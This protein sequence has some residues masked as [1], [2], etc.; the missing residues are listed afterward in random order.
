[1]NRLLTS[2][3]TVF[4]LFVSMGVRCQTVSADDSIFDIKN[5]YNPDIPLIIINTVNQEE[6]VYDEIQAPGELWGAGITNATKVP[7]SMK[8]MLCDS[9]MY[10]SGEYVSKTSG[11]TVK[12]RGNTSSYYKKKPYKIKLQRKDDLLCRG[13]SAKYGDKDWLLIYSGAMCTRTIVGFWVNELFGM[14]WTPQC[15]YVNVVMNGKYRGFYLLTEAVERNGSCRLNVNKQSGY[16]MEYDAYW[17]NE[18]LYVESGYSDY[19]NYTFKYP[20]SEDVTPEQIQYITDATRRMEASFSDGTYPDHIDVESFAAWLLAHD[21]LGT[22]DS[23]GS[24]MFLTKFNEQPENKFTMGNLWDFDMI[25]RMDGAWAKVHED[26]NAFFY[27]ALF[28]SENKTF[29]EA[30]IRKWRE[31]SDT[32]VDR[33]NERL[34]N[35]RS[36]SLASSVEHYHVLDSIVSLW[37]GDKFDTEIGLHKEWFAKRKTWMDNAV[38]NMAL[39]I[40]TPVVKDDK[41]KVFYNLQGQRVGDSYRGVVICNGRKYIKR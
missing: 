41:R 21:L 23:G 24:N 4:M 31:V 29:T 27:P 22:W 16:I 20:D 12:V 2:I 36:S 14:Q 7:G 10:E 30:Y 9:V 38:D 25:E 1:M 15:R 11:M 34:D 13:D 18:D 40:T 8:I 35:L 37:G 5:L 6:P 26:R 28:G 39:S 19:L 3:M 17:W 33:I 32:I